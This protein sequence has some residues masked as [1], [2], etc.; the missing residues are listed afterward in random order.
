[1]C[2]FFCCCFFVFIFLG[3][4]GG[5]GVGM[6]KHVS[7]SSVSELSFIS[8]I[9]L[10]TLKSSVPSLPFSWEPQ[11]L[12]SVFLTRMTSYLDLWQDS[13]V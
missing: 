2:V 13:Q 10:C 8:L 12:M 1:M 9:L 11:G 4:G 7:V 6:G 5:G 3:G